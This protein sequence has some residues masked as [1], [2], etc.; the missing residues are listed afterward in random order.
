MLGNNSRFKGTRVFPLLANGTPWNG[1]ITFPQTIVYSDV[2]S[3]DSN[4]TYYGFAAVGTATSASTWRIF[5]LDKTS[6]LTKLY[7]DGVTTFT[8]EYDERENYNY[9]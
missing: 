1:D 2:D 4:I 5:R 6:G 3:N 7:A 9:S 8:K